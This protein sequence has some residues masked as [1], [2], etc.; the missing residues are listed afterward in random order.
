MMIDEQRQAILISGESGAGKTESAKMVMQY[1]AHRTAPAQATTAR[2][3]VQGQPGVS[4]APVEEQ[5]HTCLLHQISQASARH[6][7]KSR[8]MLAC[9]IKIAR[10]EHCTCARAGTCLLVAAKHPGINAAPLEE[11]LHN[12]MLSEIIFACIV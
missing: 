7:W 11:H 9:Y 6:L 2:P 5:V 3:R 12:C 8:Y 1:L 4:T 10:R